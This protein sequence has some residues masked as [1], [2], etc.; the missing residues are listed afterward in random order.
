MGIAAFGQIVDR[1]IQPGPEQ[2]C[3]D[4]ILNDIRV[5]PHLCLN[6][7]WGPKGPARVEP[8]R[9][10]LPFLEIAEKDAHGAIMT[11]L[12]TGCQRFPNVGFDDIRDGKFPNGPAIYCRHKVRRYC[13]CPL[14]WA[15]DLRMMLR[16]PPTNLQES[17]VGAFAGGRFQGGGAPPTFTHLEPGLRHTHQEI[18]LAW[19]C[20]GPYR[21]LGRKGNHPTLRQHALE[22]LDGTVHAYGWVALVNHGELVKGEVR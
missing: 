21:M 17:F 16:Q 10:P 7:A 4:P 9:N 11:I 3:P 6:G 12:R 1:Q 5:R 18:W 22:L 2:F 13:P 8:G 14:F 19:W 20:T 15:D